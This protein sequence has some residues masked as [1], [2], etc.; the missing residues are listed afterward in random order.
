[1]SEKNSSVF[2][3]DYYLETEIEEVRRN[4]LMNFLYSMLIL[5]VVWIAYVS[6]TDYVFGPVDAAI[7]LQI[8]TWLITVR[9]RDERYTWACRIFILGLVTSFCMTILAHPEPLTIAIGV[10]IIII[11]HSLHGITQ[12]VI[13]ATLLWSISSLSWYAIA[14]AGFVSYSYVTLLL[15]G[16]TC[17]ICWIAFYPLGTMITLALRDWKRARESL[18]ETRESRGE[19]YEALKALEEATHRIERMNQELIAAHAEA[20][21]ARHDKSRFVNIVS[22]ELRGPLNIVLGFTRLMVLSPDKYGK[23]LPSSY[24]EDLHAVY[25]S[26]K[27]VVN[28]LD[29]ILD[30]GQIEA[31]KLPLKKDWIDLEK[32]V[33]EKAADIIRPLVQ[34]KGLDLNLELSRDLPHVMADE[35]RLRQVLLNLLNNAVRFTEAGS[36]SIRSVFRDD[37]IMVSVADTGSGIPEEELAGIFREFH[38]VEEQRADKG[39]GLGLAI[40]RELVE[41]HGGR[42]W[43]DSKP[44]HGSTFSFSLPIIHTTQLLKHSPIPTTSNRNNGEA[45]T[46][47]AVGLSPSIIRL[48]VRHLGDYRIVNLGAQ[49]IDRTIERLHPHAILTTTRL[50]ENIEDEITGISSG[51]P[52]I[53]VGMSEDST[54]DDLVGISGYLTKPVSPEVLRSTMEKFEKEETTI[55]LVD[56]DRDFLRFAERTLTALPHNYHILKAHDGLQAW[57]LMQSTI[58]D[59]LFMDLIMPKM[60]GEELLEKLKSD[61]RLRKVP[62]IIISAK[63]DTSVESS[64]HLPLK[65]QANRSTEMSKIVKCIQSVLDILGPNY[66]AKKEQL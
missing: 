40:S 6:V 65:I 38:Q 57:K 16:V 23:P 39:S 60:K 1:M 20:E 14:D 33:C 37:Q 55:L 53:S 29:D 22:H 47:L 56:D 61:K 45:K 58:P 13:T 10:P 63:D 66:L 52:V 2:D 25:R 62:V 36:I 30:L 24:Q 21:K 31:E 18:K 5:P 32:D 26:A 7:L 48:L 15:Y 11:A 12:S 34:R 46:C 49:N 28:L 3:L 35:V 64:L 41:L 8:P 27:H 44:G 59:I 51:V 4:T 19:A 17:G 50:A 9:L 54:R 42:M 43:A